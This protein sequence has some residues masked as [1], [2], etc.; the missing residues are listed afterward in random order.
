MKKGR[1][2]PDSSVSTPSESES[3]SEER[4]KQAKKKL[5]TTAKISSFRKKKRKYSSGLAKMQE[6]ILLNT[7]SAMLPTKKNERRVT[8]Y[9]KSY[10][11][12]QNKIKISMEKLKLAIKNY[13]KA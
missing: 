11:D 13:Q 2:D 5:R 9:S 3:S 7:I 4:K 12:M 6:E 10:L 1:K 8:F